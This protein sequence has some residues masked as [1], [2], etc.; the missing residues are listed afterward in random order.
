[1]SDLKKKLIPLRHAVMATDLSWD[2]L[3]ELSFLLEYS[4][5]VVALGPKGNKSKV[6]VEG[7]FPAKLIINHTADTDLTYR[8]E[9]VI[10]TELSTSGLTDKK[11]QEL[12]IT[13]SQ[14]HSSLTLIFEDWIDYPDIYPHE[15]TAFVLEE[16]LLTFI[17]DNGIFKASEILQSLKEH[18]P[19]Q[20]NVD[21][22]TENTHLTELSDRQESTL[23]KIIG[24]LTRALAEESGNKFGT[25]NKP[26]LN[27][28]YEH[29]ITRYIPES[30][31]RG[32]SRSS[33]YEHVQ[34]ALSEVSN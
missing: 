14:K 12:G 22:I 16:E 18:K 32:L 17:E 31:S 30:S 13:S 25:A 9:G 11:C 1:M 24:T 15:A 33:F 8:F 26:N 19:S 34:K 3:K 4:G 6:F 20:K 27:Q 23:L 28:I 21:S 5:W 29:K 2:E 10:D 7:I